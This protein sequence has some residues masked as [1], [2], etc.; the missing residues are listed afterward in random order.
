[1]LPFSQYWEK[2]LGDEG[3]FFSYRK[4]YSFQGGR[5]LVMLTTAN[6]P[7]LLKLCFVSPKSI[8]FKHIL[9]LFQLHHPKLPTLAD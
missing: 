7:T 8:V 5:S 2:G 1:R 6:N 3:F 4:N 9:R